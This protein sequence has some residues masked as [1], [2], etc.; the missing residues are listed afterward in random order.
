[1]RQY[2]ACFRIRSLSKIHLRACPRPSRLPRNKSGV[3]PQD[4]GNG[5]GGK[6]GVWSC[7]WSV[8]MWQKPHAPPPAL[9]GDPQ[10]ATFRIRPVSTVP[11]IKGASQRCASS[12]ARDAG[13]LSIPDPV[14]GHWRPPFQHTLAFSPTPVTRR[15]LSPAFLGEPCVRSQHPGR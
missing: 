8:S 13:G 12:A 15:Q 2:R 9:A 3:A 5:R 10:G 14:S 7:L 4:E 11:G 6:Q 1:M